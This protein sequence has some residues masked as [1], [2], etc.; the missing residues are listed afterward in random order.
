MHNGIILVTIKEHNLKASVWYLISDQHLN[1]KL[2][3]NIHVLDGIYNIKDKSTLCILVANYTDKHVTF[4]K[5][6]CRGHEESPIDHMPQTAI[7]SLTTQRM[8]DEHI[9][10]DTFTSPLHTLPYDVR[11]SLIQL[12]ETFKSQFAQDETSIGTTHLTKMQIDMGYSEPVL[13]KPYFI[14]MKHYDW[15]RSEINKLLDSW[16]MHN[17]HSS[18]SVPITVVPKGDGGKCLVI[19]FKQGN[20]EIC[21]AHAKNGGHLFKAEWC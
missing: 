13:Q 11:K 19:G 12:L 5:G 9:Q 16:V 15:V 17:S 1:R 8:L 21:M 7:S 4:S 20:T 14:T 3:P 10:H 2:N 18:W 6:R